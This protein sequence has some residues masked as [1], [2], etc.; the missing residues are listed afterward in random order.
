LGAPSF[1]TTTIDAASSAANRP[2][3]SGLKVSSQFLAKYLEFRRTL[4]KFRREPNRIY[5]CQ[6][7]FLKTAT[8]NNLITAVSQN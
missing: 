1:I 6:A 4:S 7:S 5:W 3:K 2:A 8:P